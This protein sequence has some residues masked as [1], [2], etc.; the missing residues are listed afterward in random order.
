MTA[1]AAAALHAGD[2]IIAAPDGHPEPAI[3]RR[4]AA[5]PDGMRAYLEPPG[6][7]TSPAVPDGDPTLAY[8]AATPGVPAEAV[9]QMLAIARDW[10]AAALHPDCPDH[11][12]PVCYA[13]TDLVERLTEAAWA[14]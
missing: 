10:R 8:V 3:V 5:G 6:A 11:T 4:L 7:A 9:A 1:V 2:V 12:Y 14:A 13:A